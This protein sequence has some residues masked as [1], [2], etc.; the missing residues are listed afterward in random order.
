LTLQLQE[1]ELLNKYTEDNRNILNVRNQIQ[2]VQDF[3]DKQRKKDAAGA[4]VSPDPIYQEVQKQILQTQAELS[5]M[6]VKSTGLESQIGEVDAEMQK[7]D[8]LGNRLKTLKTEIA[9]NEQKYRAYQQKLDEAKLFDELERQKMTS[10]SIIE[11]AGV[12]TQPLK[13]KPLILFIAMGLAMGLGGGVALALL[14]ES[15]RQ[16]LMSPQDAE[17][18]LS[19][20]VLV[21]IPY[22]R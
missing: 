7:L 18:R 11:P 13:R 14:I 4:T 9:D 16:G 10:V 15:I 5:A 8:S 21:T 17:R 22:K 1:K 2:M 19:L 3:M 6:Q 12:P 20:P